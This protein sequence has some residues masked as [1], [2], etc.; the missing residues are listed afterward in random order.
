MEYSWPCTIFFDKRAD[1]F[2]FDIT[3]SKVIV[4][5]EHE[6]KTIETP[7][8]LIAQQEQQIRYKIILKTLHMLQTGDLAAQMSLQG[9]NGM[10]I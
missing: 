2:G 6:H 8:C 9:R 4:I 7:L 5:G 10:S 1:L 3:N